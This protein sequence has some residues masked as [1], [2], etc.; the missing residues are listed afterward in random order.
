MG[1]TGGRQG[2]TSTYAAAG[3]NGLGGLQ[4]YTRSF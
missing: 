1:G 2:T 3:A 4:I